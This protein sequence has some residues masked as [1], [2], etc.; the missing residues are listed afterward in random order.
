MGA[1]PH[2]DKQAIAHL[3]KLCRIDLS[4]EEEGEIL[5]S[6][7]KVFEYFSQLQEVNTEGVAPCSYV[8]RSMLKNRM[9]DDVV[10]EVL[11]RDQFLANA[12]DQIGGMIRVPPILKS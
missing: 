2:F 4:Q 7:N 9:R 6:L 11:S 1:M 5:N 8:L 12:P 10:S 3:K